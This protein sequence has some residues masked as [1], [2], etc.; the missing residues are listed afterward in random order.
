MCY[1]VLSNTLLKH[2]SRYKLVVVNAWVDIPEEHELEAQ[3]HEEVHK[4]HANDKD[5]APSPSPARRMWS[6]MINRKDREKDR[7]ASAGARSLGDRESDDDDTKKEN[8][9]TLSA[10]LAKRKWGSVVGR[11]GQNINGDVSLISVKARSSF[12]SK[13]KPSNAQAEGEDIEKSENTKPVRDEVVTATKGAFSK[14]RFAIT[15]FRISC[16]CLRRQSSIVTAEIK[17]EECVS[18][19]NVKLLLELAR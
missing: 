11:K 13:D 9:R 7:P 10:D 19:A 18:T 6:S 1:L 4:A 16:M 14:L 3:A 15:F 2:S 17:I 12:N 8:A 5:C